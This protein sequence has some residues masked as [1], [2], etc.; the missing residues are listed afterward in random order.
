M[1]TRK[2]PKRLFKNRDAIHT[3]EHERSTKLGLKRMSRDH[4]DVLQ[5]IEFALVKHARQCPTIDD[6]MIDQALR[7]A[8]N[9]TDP[10]DAA[11]SEVMRLCAA[12]E[13]MRSMREDVSRENWIAA[14]LTV[15]Q[16]VRRHSTLAPGETSY[17][18]FVRNYVR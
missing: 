13:S 5:T 16:S 17:L 9:L 10:P 3:Y 8:I 15:D 2:P 4:I 1:A 14:L 6:H 18:D 11:G 12:L 7:C